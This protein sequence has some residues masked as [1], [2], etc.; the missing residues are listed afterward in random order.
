MSAHP[1]MLRPGPGPFFA[2]PV[3]WATLAALVSVAWVALLSSVG[4]LRT[5]DRHVDFG[6]DRP[7]ATIA[8]GLYL[9]L[10]GPKAA[11]AISITD[12]LKPTITPSRRWWAMAGLALLPAIGLWPWSGALQAVVVVWPSAGLYL[13]Y[14]DR[15]RTIGSSSRRL[16]DVTLMIALFNLL[17]GWLLNRLALPNPFTL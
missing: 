3:C 15:R 10:S 1:P 2:S 5:H 11:L 16:F 7:L 13:V 12:S 6:V 14:A 4:I 8:L 17:P 9:A